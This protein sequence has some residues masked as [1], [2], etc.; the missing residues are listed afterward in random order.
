MDDI[1]LKI[2][3]ALEKRKHALKV[4]KHHCDHFGFSVGLFP[5]ARDRKLAD[6]PTIELKKLKV[7]YPPSGHDIYESN[8]TQQIREEYRR[9]TPHPDPRGGRTCKP[10]HKL[11]PAKLQYTVQANESVI[12][13]DSS[14]GE[15]ISVVICNFSNSNRRLLDWMNGVIMENNDVW[16]SVRVSSLPSLIM[17]SCL[18]VIFS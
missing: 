7:E 10:F 9:V 5:K 17:T 11:N 16:R 8:A 3:T 6:I 14:T 4:H 1:P 13:R 12:I 18:N 2:S 15:I